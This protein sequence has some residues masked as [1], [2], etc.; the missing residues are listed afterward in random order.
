LRYCLYWQGEWREI[1]RLVEQTQPVLQQYGTPVLRFY[2]Y[3]SLISVDE[4]RNRYVISEDVLG[5]ARAMLAAA[6]ESGELRLIGE[7]HFQ[8]GF[9]RLVHDDFDEAEEQ[10]RAAE[11][12]LRRMGDVLYLAFVLTYWSIL[13]R[14][15]GQP[16]AARPYILQAH[17]ATQANKIIPHM[18][19]A[20]GNLAWLC[21]REQKLDEAQ[22]HGL[23]AV[24]LWQQSSFAYPFHWTAC[25]PL[26]AVAVRNAQTAEAV[27]YARALLEPTQQRLPEAL[28]APLTQAVQFYEQGLLE[29]ARTHLGQAL[30]AA[31]QKHYL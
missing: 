15:R 30:A 8:L 18:A 31:E 4:R 22:R 25:L 1:A 17:A 26:I 7:G 12:S 10:L 20:E 21:L 9:C 23:T 19:V 28:D 16:D 5:Y 3:D 2:F 24:E 29:S 6:Q 13:Y 14:R 27:Q 11:A